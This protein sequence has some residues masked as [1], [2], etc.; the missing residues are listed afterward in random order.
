MQNC[1]AQDKDAYQGMS[2][3]GQGAQSFAQEAGE[4]DRPLADECISFPQAVPSG[5]VR[6]D[7]KMILRYDH[8]GFGRLE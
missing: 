2:Q 1:Q 5:T 7:N 4:A 6:I 8:S 3:A